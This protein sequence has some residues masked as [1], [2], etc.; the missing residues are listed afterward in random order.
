MTGTMSSTRLGVA[1]L[2]AAFDVKPGYLAA[3]G[4]GVLPRAAVAAMTADL[5]RCGLGEATA[6]DYD[7]I[8]T[9]SRGLFADI[10][11]VPA[12]WVAI[13]PAVS[14]MVAVVAAGLPDGAEVLVADDEFSSMVLPF[15]A[16][17][18]LVVRTVPLV[19]LAGAITDDTAVV[20]FSL[21]QSATGEVADSVAIAARAR[22][23]QALSVVDLTQAAGVMGVD[24][25]Q[26]D[27]TISHVY[28]WLCSPRGVA[29]LTVRPEVLPRLRPVLA[30]WY[31]DENPWGNCYWPRVAE[32]RGARQFDTSPAWQA[33]VGARESLRLFAE[34]DLEAVWAHACDL[35]DQLCRGL[36]IPEQHRAIV[37][38][39][40]PDHAQLARLTAAGLRASGPLGL[41]RVAFHV[42]NTPEDVAA[43]LQA[44][45]R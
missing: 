39:P 40:D 43:V 1:E 2:A 18:R 7:A 4:N 10:V 41:I 27:V 11:G 20:A 9:Q 36:G 16:T 14:P 34:A 21:V 6:A 32:P 15:R 12:E 3:C 28:K 33:F 22:A 37:S 45:G 31:S 23:H 29:F 35:G 30:G 38:W 19:E 42:W 5:A 17:G 8:V 25:T 44:L 24:A 13:G 26:F